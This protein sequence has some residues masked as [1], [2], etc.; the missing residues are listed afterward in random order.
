MQTSLRKMGNSTGLIVPRALLAEIG[1]ATGTA[2]EIRVQDGKLVATPVA[3]VARQGWA[4]A[5]AAL[6]GETPDADWQG[7]GNEEDAE[8]IW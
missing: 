2:M 7:F 5:A 8:L 1:A 3:S 4:E 6:A